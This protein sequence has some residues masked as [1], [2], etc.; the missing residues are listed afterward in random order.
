MLADLLAAHV[1]GFP[2]A[3][4]VGDTVPD[5]FSIGTAL[6]HHTSIAV[7]F[8]LTTEGSVFT[9]DRISSDPAELKRAVREIPVGPVT[10]E[11]VGRDPDELL[12]VAKKAPVGI[13]DVAVYFV[14][15]YYPPN[16]PLTADGMLGC[17]AGLFAT[18][19]PRVLVHEEPFGV[20]ADGLLTGE[21][22]IHAIRTYPVHD[23]AGVGGLV[24]PARWYFELEGKSAW[25]LMTPALPV[26][27]RHF[28]DDH[29]AGLAV[30]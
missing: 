24:H 4:L 27:S 2:A 13:K 11:Y 26:C 30:S 8:S 1:I 29:F 10:V 3:V 21:S 19:Q 15:R 28:G 6:P 25:D 17:D 12:A 16:P 9:F 18:I 14:S 7:P 20:A 5:A 22:A 23:T